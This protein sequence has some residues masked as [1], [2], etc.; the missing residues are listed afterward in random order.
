MDKVTHSV[1]TNQPLSPATLVVT[2]RAQEQSSHGG[3]EIGF[4]EAQKHGFPL[5]KTDLA[6]VTAKCSICEQQRP[7]LSS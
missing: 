5:T 6:T 4:S 7:T 1:D 2:Q 3:K